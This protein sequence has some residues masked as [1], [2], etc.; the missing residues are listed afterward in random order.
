MDDTLVVRSLQRFSDLARGGQR[1]CQR[2][3]RQ[4]TR[5]RCTPSPGS[6][7]RRRRKRRCWDDSARRQRGLPRS[8]RSL[9]CSAQILITT[10]PGRVARF[11]DFAHAARAEGR[12]DFVGAKSRTDRERHNHLPC[13]AIRRRI[14]S[15][16]FVAILTWLWVSRGSGLSAAIS[17][18]KRLPSGARSRF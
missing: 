7:S 12:Q 8:K 1:L 10:G 13:A 2:H 5:L 16:K 3:C 11:V 18:T 15:K 9:N 14:S 17:T 4:A 6:C